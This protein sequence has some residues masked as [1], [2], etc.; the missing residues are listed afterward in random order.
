MKN[1]EEHFWYTVPSIHPS[2][3][4]KH[5]EGLQKEKTIGKL[6]VQYTFPNTKYDISKNNWTSFGIC[7]AESLR[8][9]FSRSQKGKKPPVN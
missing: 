2:H 8:G 4:I 3:Q 7:F 5:F 6:K 9:T 1:I